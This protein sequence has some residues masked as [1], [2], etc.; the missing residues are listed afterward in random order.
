MRL[1][2][3]LLLAL[4]PLLAIV[5]WMLTRDDDPDEV[6]LAFADDPESLLQLLIRQLHPEQ[7]TFNVFARDHS[8][9]RLFWKVLV[10][11][12]TRPETAALGLRQELRQERLLL[13][14]PIHTILQILHVPPEE[15]QLGAAIDECTTVFLLGRII[16][17]LLSDATGAEGTFRGSARQWQVAST[18]TRHDPSKRFV[19][20]RELREAFID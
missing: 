11:H 4:L 6:V 13:H 10:V 12:F 15:F 18:A 3:P 2:L 20:V 8:G 16:E 19:T 17:H 14:H 9:L 7:V 1:R 5:V